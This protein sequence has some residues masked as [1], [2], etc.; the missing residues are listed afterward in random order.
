LKLVNLT[1]KFYFQT[2]STNGKRISS[3]KKKES[4]ER[5][6]FYKTEIQRY[7]AFVDVLER[8]LNDLGASGAS[9]DGG[10][11]DELIEL[12]VLPNPP[13]ALIEMDENGP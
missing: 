12:Q 1:N 8:H 10:P 3:S 13:A 11:S 7:R 5:Q 6:A 4:K 2:Q 9:G